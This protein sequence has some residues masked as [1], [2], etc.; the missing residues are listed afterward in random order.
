MGLY[1]SFTLTKSKE[2]YYVL[3]HALY[4]FTEVVLFSLKQHYDPGI[5]STGLRGVT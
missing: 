3:G 5:M 1:P 4:I 2:P